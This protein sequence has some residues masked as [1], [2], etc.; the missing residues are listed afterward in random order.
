[1]EVNFNMTT[2]DRWC[3]PDSKFQLLVGMCGQILRRVACA[4]RIF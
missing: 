4:G 1:M 3:I 2:R